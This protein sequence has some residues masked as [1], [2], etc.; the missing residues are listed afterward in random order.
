MVQPCWKTIHQVLIKP[1]GGLS[2]NPTIMPPSIYP[3]ELSFVHTKTCTWMLIAALLITVKLVSTKMFFNRSI[4][5]L[6]YIQIT[7]KYSVIE[8]NEFYQPWRDGEP[9]VYTA[10]LQKLVVKYIYCMILTMKFWKRQTSA[11]ESTFLDRKSRLRWFSGRWW[12]ATGHFKE[13]KLFCVK[14]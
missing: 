2:S 10:E 3:R 9:S 1:N 4:N 14:L 5:K 11:G 13:V 6:W 8:S 7:E 12:G